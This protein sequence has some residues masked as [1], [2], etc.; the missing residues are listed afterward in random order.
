MGENL[1]K[2]YGRVRLCIVSIGF[3]FFSKKSNVIFEKH[4]IV[5]LSMNLQKSVCVCDFYICLETI[6][7][8]F[9]LETYSTSHMILVD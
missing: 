5:R 4:K 1:R 3:P 6:T 7:K 8:V 2:L 9:Y